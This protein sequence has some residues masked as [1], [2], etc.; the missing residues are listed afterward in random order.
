ML[1]VQTK[2]YTKNKLKSHFDLELNPMF[3]I[4]LWYDIILIATMCHR[5]IIL[6]KKNM[7]RGMLNQTIISKFRNILEY[8]CYKRGKEF[9]IVDETNITKECF[10]CEHLEHKK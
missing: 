7:H 3:V 4:Q 10:Y 1:A 9:K 2:K 6:F 8:V 5:L